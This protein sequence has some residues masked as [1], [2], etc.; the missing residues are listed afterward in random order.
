LN[1][2]V[3]LKLVA[4]SGGGVMLERPERLSVQEDSGSLRTLFAIHLVWLLPGGRATGDRSEE[5]EHDEA[6]K[7]DGLQPLHRAR[8]EGAAQ[9]IAGARRRAV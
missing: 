3:R 4:L 6:A 2:A 8:R 1:G 5:H 7:H 9:M